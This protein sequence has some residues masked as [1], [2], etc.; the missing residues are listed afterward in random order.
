MKRLRTFLF[1]FIGGFL[2]FW[3]IGYFIT[4]NEERISVTRQIVNGALSGGSYDFEVK[5]KNYAS[6]K[7]QAQGNVSASVDQKYEKVATIGAATNDFDADEAKLKGFIKEAKALIQY[8][9]NYGLNES[10]VL[11]LAIGV[12]PNEFDGLVAKLKGLGK[13][14]EFR[15]DVSD[16]TNEYNQLTAKRE[17]L[18]KFRES[19][20]QLKSKS[21]KIEELINLEERILK[22][23]EEMQGLGINLGDFDAENEFST[24]KFTLQEDNKLAPKTS[25]IARTFA[26]AFEWALLYYGIFIFLFLLFF[27]HH[28]HP[29]YLGREFNHC[30]CLGH[31]FLLATALLC[32]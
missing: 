17:T 32:Q 29:K 2:F 23:D 12:F 22:I 16:K 7:M 9:K 15:S 1:V 30:L 26:R 27:S 13:L 14:V 19:L 6:N 31:N 4:A 24:I 3:G 10:R 25:S 18:S 8:E 5:R 28:K 20:V 21:G 11:Q